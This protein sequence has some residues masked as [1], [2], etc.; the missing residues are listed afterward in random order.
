[1]DDETSPD[2]P[3]T[4]D[5]KTELSFLFSGANC[6]FKLYYFTVLLQLVTLAALHPSE[7]REDDSGAWRNHNMFWVHS[8]PHAGLWGLFEEHISGKQSQTHSRLLNVNILWHLNVIVFWHFID[9]SIN[10][11]DLNSCQ[12]QPS[13]LWYWT[14]SSLRT[15]SVTSNRQNHLFFFILSLRSSSHLSP[16]PRLFIGVISAEAEQTLA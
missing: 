7:S 15:T 1:M 6:S 14:M 13:D 8:P 11:E 5:T 2:F 3:P 9:E 4:R 16:P 12:L 10:Q